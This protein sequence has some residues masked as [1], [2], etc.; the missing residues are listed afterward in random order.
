MGLK[1][2]QDAICRNGNQE[3]GLAASNLPNKVDEPGLEVRVEVSGAGERLRNGF[4][5]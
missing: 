4:D 1:A 5:E 2:H 3:Y